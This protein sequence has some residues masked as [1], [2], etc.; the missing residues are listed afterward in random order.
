MF[1]R[2]AKMLYHLERRPSHMVT[3][4]PIYIV[5]SFALSAV[6][7]GALLSVRRQRWL[8]RDVKVSAKQRQVVRT[9]KPAGA[10][11]VSA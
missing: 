1:S 5:V 9:L 4:M 2:S 8:T 3:M 6:K 10:D 11:K 7:L